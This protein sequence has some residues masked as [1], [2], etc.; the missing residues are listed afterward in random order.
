LGE[1]FRSSAQ[2]KACHIPIVRFTVRYHDKIFILLCLSLFYLVNPSTLSLAHAGQDEASASCI[3]LEKGFWKAHPEEFERLYERVEPNLSRADLEAILSQEE[4]VCM[5]EAHMARL[6]FIASPQS[7]RMQRQQHI[8]VVPRM[9]NERTLSEG[10]AF[11]Q[12]HRS[13]FRRTY[14]KTG[15]KPQDIVAILNWESR[16]GQFRGRY[17]VLRIF[18]GQIFLIDEMERWHYANG[19]YDVENSMPRPQALQRIERIKSRAINNL[20]ELLIQAERGGFDVTTVKGSW[21]GAIGIPQFM[22]ASMVYAADG[23]GD[24][25]VDLNT[26]PD[27]I[28]SVGNYLAMNGYHSRG[29]AH[30]FRR[31]N[32]EGEYVRGVALYSEKVE[33]LGVRPSSRWA[34]E[35]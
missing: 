1:R 33:M 26:I 10:A 23:D 12:D 13:V 27:A 35:G 8:D 30:A 17:D 5:D 19:S 24:G 11:F 20:G 2:S 7:V 29:S 4:A 16:L 14:E 3:H 28:M 25:R 9:V 34:Y 15:V 22:P 21:A 6:E 32:P 18:V 31:Y